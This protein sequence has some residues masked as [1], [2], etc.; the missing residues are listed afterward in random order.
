MKT[1]LFQVYLDDEYDKIYKQL[2][3]N[4]KL[5]VELYGLLVINK[6]GEKTSFSNLLGSSY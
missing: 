1:N 3:G 5:I 6:P 2:S 4:D